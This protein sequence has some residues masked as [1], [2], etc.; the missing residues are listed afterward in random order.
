MINP[1]NAMNPPRK[2]MVLPHIFLLA[3]A[4]M[5]ESVKYCS[6]LDRTV[7]RKADFD[8]VLNFNLDII[9]E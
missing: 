1:Y 3:L 8:V 2:K 7:G 6:T 9:F 4:E 5:P